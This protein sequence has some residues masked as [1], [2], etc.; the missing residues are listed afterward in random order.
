MVGDVEAMR[1]GQEGDTRKYRRLRKTDYYE[2]KAAV[3]ADKVTKFPPCKVCGRPLGG[4]RKNF[5][6]FCLECYTEDL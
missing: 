5:N 1:I 4:T 6:G 3:D 2:A